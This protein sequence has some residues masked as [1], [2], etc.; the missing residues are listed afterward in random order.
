MTPDQ[1]DVTPQGRDPAPELGQGPHQARR[2]RCTGCF[3]YFLRPA[4][5]QLRPQ[6]LA[7]TAC[8]AC[9]RQRAEEP[10]GP[11]RVLA[12]R[13]RRVAA[14]P[15][16][17]RAAGPTTKKADEA[18]PEPASSLYRRRRRDPVHHPGLPDSVPDAGDRLQVHRQHP[19]PEHRAGL[20]WIA[21]NYKTVCTN[22]WNLYTLY[23]VER[24]GV[25]S[26][27]QVLRQ[28]RLVQ[29]R[30]R[31]LLKTQ[32]EDGSWESEGGAIPSTVWGILFLVR[33]A[34]PV[35]FNKLDYAPRRP[36]GGSGGG[37]ADPGQLEPAPARR[38]QR[39]ALDRQDA[40]AGPQLADR[41]PPGRRRRPARRPDPLHLRQPG[42]ELL[43]RRK[44][45][46]QAVRR[47]GRPD[48]RQRRLQ[49]AA[50]RHVVHASW[51]HEMFKGLRVPR[52]ADRPPD[53]HRPASTART[54]V[55]PPRRSW[56]CP[57]APAS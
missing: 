41:Q 14:Q 53:L 17:R 55:S 12:A 20:K 7:T 30:R 48:P 8:W 28:G 37:N 24:I 52:A 6:H 42:A 21:D 3:H 19:G 54:G 9:G 34:R 11:D 32:Q 13:R 38:R 27:L 50:V 18:A 47:A 51:A 2:T 35:M 44:G 26:G 25:A 36:S 46:A 49:R 29:G 56:A 4:P 45:Q 43:A 23:D 31:H 40:R 5:G 33:G 15:G 1:K 10:R 39:R 16:T 22:G 57:T